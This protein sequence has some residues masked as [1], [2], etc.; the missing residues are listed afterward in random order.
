V[1]HYFFHIRDGDQFEPD[2]YGLELR[3]AEAAR[4]EALRAAGEMVRDAAI[5]GRDVPARSL[6]VVDEADAPVVSVAFSL[7]S[8]QASR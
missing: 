7:I 4:D 8:K 2:E 1:P 3:D 6:E 5:A